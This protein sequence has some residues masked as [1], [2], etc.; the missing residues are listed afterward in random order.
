MLYITFTLY[1]HIYS[2]YV[3]IFI[4]YNICV[5]THICLCYKDMLSTESFENLIK[6]EN[7]HWIPITTG[8]IMFHSSLL[9][10]DF[11]PRVERPFVVVD[12]ALTLRL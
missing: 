1:I 11:F 12:V 7:V 8:D 2:K 6:M 3:Y 5:Y 9:Q 10:L 4:V